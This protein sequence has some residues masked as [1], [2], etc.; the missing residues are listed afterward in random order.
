MRNTDST[1]ARA[2][3]RL[4]LFDALRAL[5]AI[6]I[7]W[8][9]TPESDILQRSISLTRFAVPFFALAAVFFTFHSLNRRPGQPFVAY[10]RARF[11]R[12]YLPFLGWALIYHLARVAMS[13][14]S[15]AEPERLG[16]YLLWTGT[17]HHLWFMPFI[18]VV[19]LVA[20]WVAKASRLPTL[21]WIISLVCL[22]A[23]TYIAFA[24][25]RRPMWLDDIGPG[26]TGRLDW[27]YAIRLCWDTLPAVLWG[28]AVSIAY[29]A[30]NRRLFQNIFVALIGAVLFVAALT[31]LYAGSH[32]LPV[33]GHW[34]SEGRSTA[35]E[36][37][38]GLGLCLVALQP[39]SGSLIRF[40]ARFGPLTFGIYLSHI[41]FVEGWQEA[42]KMLHIEA[43]W[44]LD[45]GVFVIAGTCTIATVTL[46]RTN[47][48]T[49]WLGA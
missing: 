45:A 44:M 33:F 40:V 31:F 32:E 29:H 24:A 15:S 27:A 14:V 34:W 10:T 42:A 6:A 20:F 7:I 49:R 4:E 22:I 36:N 12:I 46:L 9:H 23:G 41:L 19:C 48:Y 30:V 16:A 35:A 21:G 2:T 28:I 26:I 18:F 47:R 38:A 5:G 25:A 39:W 37:L 3:T 11:A 17:T 13:Y 43:S 8:L 1:A